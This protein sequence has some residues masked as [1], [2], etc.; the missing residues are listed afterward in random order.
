MPEAATITIINDEKPISI[1]HAITEGDSLWL[2]ADELLRTTGWELKPQGLC[3]NDL[4]YPIPAGRDAE[5]S[6][7]VDGVPYL[8]FTALADLMDKPWAGD[9]KHR[10]WYFGTE[11]AARRNA[12]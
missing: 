10:V 4:C 7:K 5:F 1:E 6:R 3:R 2:G 9:S 11:T 8:N 12:L